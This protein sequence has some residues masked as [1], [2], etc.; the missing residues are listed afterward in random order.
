LFGYVSVHKPELKVKEFEIY[1]AVYCGLCRHLG[2]TYGALS[3]LC[4]NYDLTFLALLQAALQDGCDGYE[5][6]KCR[7]N[8][9]K[10]CTYCK[11]DSKFQDYAAAVCVSLTDLKLLDEVCDS[12]FLKSLFFRFLRLFSSSWSKKAYKKYPF[13]E[14]TLTEYR[15]GQAEAENTADC[16]LDLA[17]EPT[18]KALSR[19][20]EFISPDEKHKFVLSKMGYCI[21]K[22]VYLCDVADDIE[23]DIKKGNFNPVKNDVPEGVDPKKYAEERLLPN[24]NVCFVECGKYSELLDYKKYKSIVDNIIYD[25]LKNRQAKIF[26]EEKHK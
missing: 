10:K 15:L 2:C 6:K 19:I 3:K 1:N 24:M 26:E 18:A 14:D 13:L 22:W 5:Q 16:S 11:N 21:G 25:G 23:K 8:P 4:L 17:A 9:L 7:A 20:F 12:G